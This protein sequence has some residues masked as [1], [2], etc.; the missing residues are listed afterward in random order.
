M[1]VHDIDT[2]P[3]L[4][5]ELEFADFVGKE[6]GTLNAERVAALIDA[7]SDMARTETGQLLHY[8]ADDAIELVGPGGTAL[9]LPE[10]PVIAVE[11]VTVR[12][13][14]SPASALDLD[15]GYRLELGHDGRR[16][17]IRKL[18]GRWPVGWPVTVT[19]SHGYA[20]P[21]AGSSSGADAPLLPGTIRTTIL[22]AMARAYEN[23]SGKRQ[24]QIGRYSY[25]AG[26]TD[27][28]LY[29]TAGDVRALAAYRRGGGGGSK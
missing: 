15:V 19:Y 4:V 2:G 28:G 27:P 23:P 22:R 6:V 8:I 21:H 7:G 17:I 20:L 9:V 26:G 14:S 16:G 13:S 11:S 18:S 3:P 1:T 5:T 10:V 12:Y 29:P 25:T 24:E